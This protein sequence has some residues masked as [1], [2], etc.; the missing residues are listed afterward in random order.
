[1]GLLRIRGRRPQAARAI[2]QRGRQRH[3]RGPRD[4]RLRREWTGGSARALAARPGPTV[5]PEAVRRLNDT[6]SGPAPAAGR[7]C[8]GRTPARAWAGVSRNPL[9]RGRGG[10]LG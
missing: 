2:I 10:G 1:R 3:G 6:Y 9:I 7:R 8:D 5:D 4:L